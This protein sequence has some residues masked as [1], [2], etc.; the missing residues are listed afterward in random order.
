VVDGSGVVDARADVGAVGR[1]G[2]AIQPLRAARRNYPIGEYRDDTHMRILTSLSPPSLGAARER[3]RL[4]A[5]SSQRQQGSTMPK[6]KFFA[7]L[8]LLAGV[9][10]AHA[11]SFTFD[12]DVSGLYSSGGT[13][14]CSYPFTGSECP[15][16][17][18]WD[19]VISF[20]TAG[21]DGTYWGVTG[22]L[23]NLSFPQDSAIVATFSRVV[24]SNGEV[25]SGILES[26]SG[27]DVFSFTGND[28]TWTLDHGYHGAYGTLAG[29]ITA[30]PEPAE[31]ALLMA[32]LGAFGVAA[33][34]RR[35]R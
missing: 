32:G 28:V 16:P 33:L 6:T 4:V 30:V 12:V 25:V 13:V 15:K 26:I 24:V 22:D 11:E 27:A 23:S 20:D 14:G 17:V 5:P 9:A 1:S 7:G 18:A 34:R 8:A 21:T 3:G 29:S 31:A 10:V 35:R 2:P 19:F